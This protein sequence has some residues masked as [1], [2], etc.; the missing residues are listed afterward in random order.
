M[1]NNKLNQS[2]AIIGGMGPQASAKL[3]EV[4]IDIC[5]RELG[6]KNDDD[7]PEIILSSVA[8]PDFISNQDN[9][10]TVLGILKKR[11]KLLESFDPLCFGIAC[12]TAHV[13]LNN[14]RSVTNIPFVSIID[15]VVKKVEENKI[16]SVGLLGTPVTI[17]TGLYQA[18][19]ADRNIRLIVPSLSEQKIV[20]GV[21]RNVLAGK[22]NPKDIKLLV[23][24][25]KSLK[26]RGAKGIILGCTELP[27]IFPKNFSM[28]VFDSIEI[29]ARAL[30]KQFDEKNN[31]KTGNN[32]LETEIP[33]YKELM[34]ITV[35]ENNQAFVA[36]KKDKIPFGYSPIFS[37]MEKALDNK[38]IVRKEIWKRLLKAQVLLQ[39]NNPELSLFIT[40]GYR[41]MEVQTSRFLERIKTCNK[42]FSD[43]SDL[44]QEAHRA[45]AMP[46]VAGHPTGGAVDIIIVD[47]RTQKS[48]DFGSKQYDYSNKKYYVYASDISKK[49]K[50]NRSLLRK[51]MIKAGFAPYNGEWWHFSYGDREWAYYYKKKEA[52][53]SQ[54][55]YKDLS[56]FM[57]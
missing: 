23:T 12:N 56:K 14:L 3:L 50:I 17:K 52:I 2:I 43:P 48:I 47:K 8:V 35:K 5:T 16:S 24:V 13:L 38:M 4:L 34:G 15:S 25:S 22:K 57:L 26:A 44:Y 46:T 36:L 18:K 51:S 33:N 20:E 6:A 31:K 37:E 45:V 11:V 19:L 21:I 32:L 54:I 53:Y 27:L 40:F 55:A 29:L 41:S 49:A 42:F 9:I 30:L 39:K 10:K 1:K 7:F 28:P